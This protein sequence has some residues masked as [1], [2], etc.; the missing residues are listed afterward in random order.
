MLYTK[1]VLMAVFWSGVFPAVKIVVQ[2]MGV[3]TSVF[4]RFAC[5]ALVL[6]LLLALR[7]RRIPRLTPRESVLVVG[8][9]LVGIAVYN[10]LF[11]A[12]L[13]MGFALG[14]TRKRP[15][16]GRLKRSAA[17]QAESEATVLREHAA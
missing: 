17:T 13:T 11:S 12:A 7:D 14:L 9:G 16:A 15:M 2:T 3:F 10:V 8:L 5:A 1:L 4:L 6:L